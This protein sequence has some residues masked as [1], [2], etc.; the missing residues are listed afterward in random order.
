M[1]T[2]E[3]IEEKMLQRL[4]KQVWVADYDVSRPELRALITRLLI[5]VFGGDAQRWE[6]LDAP[7]IPKAADLRRISA[8]LKNVQKLQT[9]MDETK[10]VLDPLDRSLNAESR[11]Q[12]H[13]SLSTRLKPLLDELATASGVALHPLS[14]LTRRGAP[15]KKNQEGLIQGIAQLV[16]QILTRN[17]YDEGEPSKAEVARAT[18]EVVRL[19][20]VRVEHKRIQHLLKRPVY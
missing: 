8:L 2:I 17:L 9:T 6:D 5:Y 13:S 14:R 7:V 12:E 19:V 18:A 10:H 1:T 16:Q 15:Q 20:N 3:E 11:P 4:R